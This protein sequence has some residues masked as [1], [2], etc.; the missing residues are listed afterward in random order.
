MRTKQVEQ[1][2]KSITINATSKHDLNAILFWDRATEMLSKEDKITIL[3]YLINIEGGRSDV[4]CPKCGLNE[5][6]ASFFLVGYFG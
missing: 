4:R 6:L 2:L 1:L 5:K 3:T